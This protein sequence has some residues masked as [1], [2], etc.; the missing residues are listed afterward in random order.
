MVVRPTRRL[1][2]RL[3]ARVAPGPVERW[4]IQRT[5]AMHDMAQ[6]PSEEL[7][8]A[9]YQRLIFDRVDRLG[10]RP[11]LE[12]LDLGCGQGR[13]AIPMA[14]RG[15]T[16]RGVDWSKVA[17]GRA[18]QYAR[19]A[20]VALELV[21]ADLREY[22]VSLESESVDMAVCL[23]VL[24][25]TRG[26][27]RSLERLARAVRPGGC[28]AVAVRPRPY[29]VVHL[30]RASNFTGARRV[31]DENEG[32]IFDSAIE[33]NWWD[34]STLRRSLE[35]YGLRGIELFGIGICCGLPDDPQGAWIV[36]GN[37]DPD[38]RKSL[39]DLEIVLAPRYPE[40]G[41]YILAVGEKAGGPASN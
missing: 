25:M 36:P 1:L 4:Q 23:E 16:V 11:P 18:A 37:L 15:W 13:I 3:V 19:E 5:A 14:R 24:Y 30:A 17:L 27:D 33:F 41:R 12:V 29:Y 26:A 2:Q 31:L 6:D 9:L 8:G 20:G 28:L 22:L 34:A 32:R 39:E 35:G 7:F 40:M 21:R 38:R 10:L